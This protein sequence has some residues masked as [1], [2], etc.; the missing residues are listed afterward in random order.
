MLYS[1]NAPF[2]NWSILFVNYCMQIVRELQLPKFPKYVKLLHRSEGM[3][4]ASESF[5]TT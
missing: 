2:S 1:K 5:L 4:F 3:G